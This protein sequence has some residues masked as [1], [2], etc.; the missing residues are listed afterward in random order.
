MQYTD[1]FNTFQGEYLLF[2]E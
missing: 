2:W 1:F